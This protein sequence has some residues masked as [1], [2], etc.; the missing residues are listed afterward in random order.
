MFENRIRKRID[1][2][3]SKTLQQMPISAQVILHEGFASFRMAIKSHYYESVPFGRY[4][5]KIQDRLVDEAH[6]C[7]WH[8]TG[9]CPSVVLAF[10]Y[11]H[12]IFRNEIEAMLLGWR[13]YWDRKIKA[14]LRI[15]M[16]AEQIRG[17]ELERS[18]LT[19]IKTIVP[20]H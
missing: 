17:E 13:T 4:V 11:E 10:A 7:T 18:P 2:V 5:R 1:L 19:G 14:E 20:R 12:Q 8:V 15:E 3:E 6:L 16:L 9:L